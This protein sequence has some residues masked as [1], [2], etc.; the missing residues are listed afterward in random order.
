MQRVDILRILRERFAVKRFGL[1][2]SAGAVMLQ[3]E[4]NPSVGSGHPSSARI[5]PQSLG[6]RFSFP[7]MSSSRKA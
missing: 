2:Q 7:A 5:F 6:N 1:A 3:A 4:L